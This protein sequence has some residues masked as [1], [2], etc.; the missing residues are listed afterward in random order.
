MGDRVIIRL[1]DT[2]PG[3]PE[4]DLPNLFKKFQRIERNKQEQVEGTGLGLSIVKPSARNTRAASR[5][6]VS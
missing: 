5:S 4:D 1:V 6:T 3:I 2:G